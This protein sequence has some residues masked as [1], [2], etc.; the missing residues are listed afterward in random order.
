MP[1]IA[2]LYVEAFRENALATAKLNYAD[3]FSFGDYNRAIDDMRNAASE[4]NR[5]YPDRIP[6][7][8]K[9]LDDESGFVRRWAAICLI[10]LVKIDETTQEKAVAVITSEAERLSM[11]ETEE[12]NKKMNAELLRRWLTNWAL[13]KVATVN[14]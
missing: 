12:P 1:H 11:E 5:Y 8:I 14:E 6:E 13:G 9:F 3:P 10:E 2:D 7:L 4:I